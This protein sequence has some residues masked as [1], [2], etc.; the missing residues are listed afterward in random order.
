[1]TAD[2]NAENATSIIESAGVA[3]RKEPVRKPRVFAAK[4][5]SQLRHGGT[6]DGGGG[7]RA[8]YEWQF[9]TD[10]GKT[11]V[12]APSTLQAK[13][14]VTG[15]S[16]GTTVEFRFK[17]VVKAGGATGALPGRAPREVGATALG[18]PVAA[19]RAGGRLLSDLVPVPG[20]P[21]ICPGQGAWIARAWKC[22]S[23][24]LAHP[25]RRRDTQEVLLF[26]EPTDVTI[27]I[28]KDIRDEVRQT[29]TDLSAAQRGL[30]RR[31]SSNPRY[32]RRPPSRT[33]QLAVNR[34]TG[35]MR[36]SHD[37]RPRWTSNKDIAE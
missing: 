18:S 23:P 21:S 26:L 12:S 34:M 11:W 33:W 6:G 28:L 20:H 13:T 35:V 17:S 9:S 14:T 22:L 2:A 16:A 15:L 36:A 3:V 4:P 30:S 8:S 32:A 24:T 29:R 10:G 25:L 7:R 37:L 1:M 27:E 31:P 19:G 5:G